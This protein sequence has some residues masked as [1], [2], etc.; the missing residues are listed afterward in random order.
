MINDVNVVFCVLCVFGS[1]VDNF[2][3][4]SLKERKED[5]LKFYVVYWN[6]EVAAH[7]TF[8]SIY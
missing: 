5:N 8:N 6:L 1:W 3:V 7:M 2:I 4:Y